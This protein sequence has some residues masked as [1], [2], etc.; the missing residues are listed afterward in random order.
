MYFSNSLYPAGSEDALAM[1]KQ[2]ESVTNRR[3]ATN[4]HIATLTVNAGRTPESLYLE[5][6][7]TI[8]TEFKLDEGDAILNALM[9]LQKSV[10]IGRTIVEYARSSDSGVASTS[11]SGTAGIKFD[12][13]EYD[14]A[15]TLVPMH[16][17]GFEIPFREYDQ[18]RL[19]GFDM[20]IDLQRE[21]ARTLRQQY[22]KFAMDG[23]PITHKGKKWQ[24]FRADPTVEQ[25]SLGAGGLNVDFTSAS[26][27]GANFRNGF[28][29]LV[30]QLYVTNKINVPATYFVSNEILFNAQRYYADT[31]ESGMIL[32]HLKRLT[33]VA[34]IV[35]TSALTG[36]QVLAIVLNK[37]FIQPVVGMAVNTVALSRPEYNSP[38][39]WATWGAMG[40][41]V[42]N[43]WKGSSGVMYAAS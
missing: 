12:G 5:F 30:K 23:S 33:G 17:T 6:D 42:K 20:T 24:G 31:Y 19:D 9:P 25:V 22:V 27:T 41:L 37:S 11:M 2:F 7:R 39:R 18:Q 32:D 14:T 8:T 35:A 16:D 15:G 34:D 1:K 4:H 29:A 40:I 13:I 21:S 36:N 26:L 3:N 10:S 38:Y 43:D 28:L